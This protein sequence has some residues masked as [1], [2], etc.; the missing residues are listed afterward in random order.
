MAK[1]YFTKLILAMTAIVVSAYA[2][3]AKAQLIEHITPESGFNAF[4]SRRFADEAVV[5]IADTDDVS[6]TMHNEPGRRVYVEEVTEITKVLGDGTVITD[7]VCGA[8]TPAMVVDSHSASQLE[9]KPKIKRMSHFAVGLELGTS[10]DVS[11][12]D[13]STFN[14]DAICGYRNNFFNLVG[15]SVGMHKSLGS[16][17]NFIPIKFHFRSSFTTRPS[18]AFFAFS[19]GYGFNTIEGSKFFGDFT[20]TI[21]CGVN[22]AR[23]PRFQSN[24]ILSFGFRHFNNRHLE[25]I[26]IQKSN[27]GYA[28]ISMGIS[29]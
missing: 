7:T 3:P 27:I 23:K 10:L 18:L 8:V 20:S 19:I 14:V 11:G 17:D 28:Q 6:G 4:D 22:L 5:S 12:N 9:V 1:N 26:T 24:I 13:Q 29:I 2:T 21:G 25:M 15:V 16:K